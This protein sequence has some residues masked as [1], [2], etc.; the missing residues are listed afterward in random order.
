MS[1]TIKILEFEKEQL[2]DRNFK[3]AERFN[4]ARRKNR[5]LVDQVR[6]LRNK[7]SDMRTYQFEKEVRSH[8]FWK[9]YYETDA[10]L[11]AAKL[12]ILS[13]QQDAEIFFCVG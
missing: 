4:E 6:Y 11:H 2:Y 10:K 12:L 3:L 13:M 8:K 1:E 5:G 7:N 9:K